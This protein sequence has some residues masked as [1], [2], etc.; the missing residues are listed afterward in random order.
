MVEALDQVE[1]LTTLME[2]RQ[3]LRHLPLRVCQSDAP[4][5]THRSMT[6]AE[7]V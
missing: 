2:V 1:A 4:V 5:L 3:V 7:V 6:Y